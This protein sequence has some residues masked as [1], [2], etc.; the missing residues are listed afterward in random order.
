MAHRALA[1]SF[2]FFYGGAA[3]GCTLACVLLGFKGSHVTVLR[4]SKSQNGAT[5]IIAM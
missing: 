4:V 1:L 5:E 2:I 3:H